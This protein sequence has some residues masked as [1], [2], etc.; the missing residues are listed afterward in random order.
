MTVL[1]EA[2]RQAWPW[3]GVWR[4]H[5]I[6]LATTITLAFM[7]S[8]IYF[9]R[10]EQPDFQSRL[11]LHNDIVSGHAPSPY[12]Y[13]VLIPFTA[14]A[15]KL[16]LSHVTVNERVAFMLA[17]SLIDVLSTFGFLVMAF[18]FFSKFYSE[19]SSLLGVFVIG[20]LMHIGLQDHAYQ[21]WS[22]LE[23]LF[24][25][26]ALLAIYEK[27]TRHL[28]LLVALASLNRE[29]AILI[30]A[31]MFIHASQGF[32]VPDKADRVAIAA[33][34]LSWVLMYGLLRYLCGQ[35]AHVL[36]LSAILYINTRPSSLARLAFN[37]FMVLGFWWL[38][39]WKG[40]FSSSSFIKRSWLILIVYAPLVLIF[41]VWFEVRLLLPLYPLLV[42]TC[43]AFI[44]V[45]LDQPLARSEARG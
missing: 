31:A 43:L 30:P 15:I 27:K 38:L 25:L 29:T 44:E 8:W 16:L 11:S 5:W 23:A 22:V 37:G 40:L 42:A 35:A 6:A 32:K 4:T 14:E 24:F 9:Q 21:P 36:S 20:A 45:S 17:Y 28:W 19:K 34:L 7:V 39:F 2:G 18:V 26:V 1:Q 33:A 10:V 3:K 41:G 13:R 12:N